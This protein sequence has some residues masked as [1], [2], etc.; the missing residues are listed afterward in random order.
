MCVSIVQIAGGLV[1]AIGL[2]LT[3]RRIQVTEEGQV[4]DRFSTAIEQ[5]AD[6]NLEA[7]LGGIYALEL[8]ARDSEKDYWT[9]METL[10]AFIR[11][12][13]S[14]QK[15]KKGEEEEL[16][17]EQ[18]SGPRTDVQAACTVIGRRN[19]AQDPEEKIIDLWKSSLWSQ[20][21]GRFGA[22]SSAAGTVPAAR[23]P[24]TARR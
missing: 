4:T 11:E 21:R 3:W 5:L 22:C 23:P 2:Y 7:R 13:A 24:A 14:S 9:A 15:A 19:T 8:I 17:K 1:V 6:E 18:D 16:A 20:P 10:S 12:N